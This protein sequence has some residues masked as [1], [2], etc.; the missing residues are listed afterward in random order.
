MKRLFTLLFL[1]CG[2]LPA[3][4]QTYQTDVLR[5]GGGGLVTSVQHHPKVPKLHYITTDVGTAYRWDST[6]QR[7][8]GLFY[9]M[10]AS[11]WPAA[12]NNIAVAPND[13]TGNIIYATL[14]RS[15][16]GGTVMKSTDGGQTWT[17]LN[18]NVRTNPNDNSDKRFGARLV[19][20]PL[21]DSTVYVTTRL[22]KSGA[23]TITGTYR[24][25]DAGATW[26]KLDT[27]HG[28][29]IVFDTAQ[30]KLNGRTK[31][32]YIACAN[33]VYLSDD[34]G[35]TYTL[36]P[37]SPAGL[38][39]GVLQANGILYATSG[40]YVYR[41]DG[42]TWTDITPVPA[43]SVGNYAAVAENPHNPQD[44]IV[45]SSNFNASMFKSSQ[46]GASGTWST[47]QG[48]RDN[49]EN[50][51]RGG[52]NIGNTIVD[53]SWEYF[54]STKVWLTDIFNAY[55]GT[56]AMTNTG[57][58]KVR[59]VGHEEVVPTGP[60]LSPPAGSAN[61]VSTN[62]ADV[63]GFDHKS[64]TAAPTKDLTVDFSYANSSGL[65]LT[66][67]AVME[68]NPN[69]M[70]RV[71]RGGWQGK[72]L[73]GFSTDG[74]LHYTQWICPDSA[75][76]GRIAVAANA[77]TLVWVPQG[78]N[79]LYSTDRGAHWT[80]CG[81]FTG[82]AFGWDIYI[83]YS[84]VFDVPAEMSPL[85]ADKVNSKKFYI[86]L[87][88]KMMVSEDGGVTFTPRAT[89]LP[90][91]G[92]VAYVKVE[93]TPGKEGDVWLSIEGNGLYHSTNSGY[94]F[95]HVSNVQSA[96]SVAVGKGATN[97]PA[98]YV[99]G[100]V[101]GVANSIF[102]SDD[103]ATTWVNIANPPASQLYVMTADRQLYGRVFF[104][105]FGNGFFVSTAQLVNPTGVV[106]TPAAVSVPAN[107][108]TTL[109]AFV[110][111][112]WANNK[113]VH[114]SSSDTT[115]VKVNDSTGVVT[116]I[117]VTSSPVTV[118]VT[119]ASGGYTASVAVT[120][121]NPI[122]VKGIAI[123]PNPDTI[124]Q[125]HASTLAVV[126]TPVDASNKTLHWSS[127]DTTVA[128][129]PLDTPVITGVGVGTA[130]ITATAVD[131]G[132]TSSITVRVIN[133]LPDSLQI[134]GAT[135]LNEGDTTRLSVTFF[136][137]NTSNQNI[138]WSSS[139]TTKAKVDANGLVTAKAPGAVTI[140]ATAAAN[141][142]TATRA[143]TIGPKAF[144][145]I[146]SNPGFE[147]GLSDWYIVGDSVNGALPAGL[148]TT[149]VHGGTQA[150]LVTGG[151]AGVSSSGVML[152][153][154]SKAVTFSAFTKVSGSPTWAGYGIDYVDSSGVKI[155]QDVFNATTTAWGNQSIT[156]VSPPNTARVNVWTYKNG[157]GGR[158][159][160][161]DFCVTIG[162]PVFV[163]SITLT[164]KPLSV[165]VGY[166]KKITP[167]IAPSN[168]TWKAVTWS[169]SNTA[170][171]TVD[172]SGNVKGIALGT[173]IITCTPS[174]RGGAIAT[175]TVTVTPPVP[176]TGV[177]VTPD[178]T[179]MGVGETFTLTAN[180]QPSNAS[181]TAMSWTSLNTT[182]ATV[183]ATTGA[184]LAKATG[185]VKIVGATVDG[186]YRDT[187][188][189]TIVAA[190]SCG[191]LTNNGFEAGLTSWQGGSLT[192]TD[193]HS[194]YR[195]AVVLTG[196]L[197]RQPALT[198]NVG[199]T[200]EFT[201]WAK[202]TGNP[203][204]AGFSLDMQTATGSKTT[205]MQ[206]TVSA[207]LWTQY[208]QRA[209]IPAG[210]T[211]FN[212]WAS[213]ATTGGNLYLDD[214]CVTVI[215]AT[216]GSSS[217]SSQVMTAGNSR[218]KQAALAPE[219]NMEVKVYPNPV[220][221]DIN[222]SV[223]NAN[224]SRMQA[225]LADMN[226]RILH[227]EIFYPQKGTYKLHLAQQPPKGVYI[228]TVT[229]DNAKGSCKLIVL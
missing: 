86:Y 227:Q 43:S 114:W 70:V 219:G 209:V 32:V 218:L 77:E 188:T 128:K 125:G 31:R 120:V 30:G 17:D 89:G 179:I 50:P 174:D 187:S 204:W 153:P 71:G 98:I 47:V 190:G 81:G 26:T 196:T 3:V 52:S 113:Q 84:Q 21:R 60:V 121:T 75:G 25:L 175:D 78:Y 15:S 193:V 186:G 79:P 74:G 58:W 8:R 68:S 95:R 194:G 189:I 216:S 88:G 24:S 214:L 91:V 107:N 132:Y 131:S 72:G 229:G 7:W 199:D 12:C 96:R 10:A 198:F 178:S 203:V 82:S 207:V 220:Q 177:N 90:D 152:V 208:T 150:V 156:R 119:T 123:T 62:T 206:A 1:C 6:A 215:P 222:I 69:F 197:S 167:T 101:G 223:S 226:G 202:I 170:I 103:T 57:V 94:S 191:A 164:P 67:T 168:A 66:S 85:A 100:T 127:S 115:K 135:S 185:T 28:R 40:T 20:D 14:N 172:G 4:A 73:G 61:I 56:N 138:T 124:V 83:D 155:E 29:F 44:I 111:P 42:I 224:G 116:G 165:A 213:K 184:V 37:G 162:T 64:L 108:T 5:I 99:Y 110:T 33:G 221:R 55:E 160:L 201:A 76:G 134:H 154:G 225:T 9:N 23:E 228:L 13:A 200:I 46:G 142:I 16:D 2:L 169:S 130:T 48:T 35:D 140:T 147:S 137:G 63:G 181:N 183:N 118:T 27:L 171:A 59:A 149:D 19:V 112:A 195:A 161:D 180:M 106:V 51:Y 22:P 41:Y 212:F 18:F 205:S 49:S 129:V 182:L 53:L 139:D 145:G 143:Y 163:S 158:L 93:T 210:T 192:T 36:L 97:L 80:K 87:Q 11:N 39:R 104:G 109:Q 136:P 105:S 144:C 45:G 65:E 122:S 211:N 126:V 176:V 38:N 92:K 102:R 217:L 159:Y 157:S 141:G 54:D 151:N 117:A 148:E 166:T 34:A 146:L 173:A 133:V